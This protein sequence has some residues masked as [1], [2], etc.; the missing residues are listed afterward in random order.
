VE[1][2]G[3]PPPSQATNTQHPPANVVH[4]RLIPVSPVSNTLPVL[5]LGHHR[6]GI[7][8]KAGDMSIDFTGLALAIIA[9]F[10]IVGWLRGVRRVAV[11]TGGVFFAMVVVSLMGPDLVTSLSHLGIRFTV[12]QHDL[13][14]ALL[15][16][17]TVY[18]VGLGAGRLILG[19][20]TGPLTRQQR[21]SGV[22]LGLLNG[23]LIVAN[24]VRYAN[25]YLQHA[26][27]SQTGGWTWHIPMLHITHPNGSTISFSIEPSAIT[28]TPSPLLKLYDKLPSALIVLFA[29]LLFVFVGTMYGRIMRR[30][31]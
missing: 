16:V 2:T 26:L 17:F 3:V 23:F 11:T 20:R 4:C 24:V 21:L 30:R 22:G 7:K 31:G 1:Y 13:F 5:Q 14:L 27:N 10:G 29:F 18:V 28:I 25:T 8:D 15:F 6:C 19:A 9:M 12:E